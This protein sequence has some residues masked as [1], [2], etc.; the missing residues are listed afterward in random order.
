V[1]SALEPP[2]AT[3]VPKTSRSAIITVVVLCFGGLCASLTQTMVIP[4]QGELAQLLGTSAGNASWVVTATLLSGAVTMPVAGRLG[5]MFG[6][7]R[8]LVIS[9]VLLL[10][11][12]LVC[13]LAD[14]L[15]PMLAGRVLQGLAFGFVPVGISLMREVT[16]PHITPTA[17]AAVSA[18]LGVGGAIGLPLSAWIAQDFNWHALFWTSAGLATLVTAA[19]VLLVPTVNNANG[20]RFD[21]VGV[22]GLAVGLVSVLVGVS[23]GNEW[24]WADARTLGCLVA[25]VVVLLAW[26]WFELRQDDPLCDLRVSAQRPVLLTNLAAVAVGFGMMAQ[27]IV[28]PQLLQMPTLTGYGLGQSLL[29]TGLWMA[30]SGLMMLLFAPVSSTLMRGIGAKGTLMIGAGVLGLGYLVAFFLM[31]A[32]WQLLIASIVTSS[33]VGI[34]YAAMPTLILSAVPMSESGSAVGI[35]GLMRSVGTSVAAAVMVALLTSSTTELAGHAVPTRSA[36]QI[37]FIVGAVAAFV[38]V[39]VTAFVPV[40]RRAAAARATAHLVAGPTKNEEVPVP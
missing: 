26:G 20:G 39:A 4:I 13:A 3:A 33:G 38:G 35:N 24:G 40:A 25:G 29:A 36:F 10:L 31:G 9:A 23:K 37:C 28:V 7:Q 14:S 19:V 8:I 32:P 34:A 22:V 12:S 15:A 16:P 11:G 1:T 27:A 5:D 21:L 2:A 18:T 6:K 30:P 17:I